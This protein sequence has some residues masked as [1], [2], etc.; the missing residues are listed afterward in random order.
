[1]NKRKISS[2]YRTL[3]PIGAA[4]QQGRDEQGKEMI[5]EERRDVMGKKEKKNSHSSVI[6]P[7]VPTAPFR[8]WDSRE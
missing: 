5:Q 8:E 4:A 3:S 2:F 7:A 6:W 1:M